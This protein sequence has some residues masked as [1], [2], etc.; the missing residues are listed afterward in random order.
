MDELHLPRIVGLVATLALLV[1]V[2]DN[3]KSRILPA[4]LG[5][6]VLYTA[7]TNIDRATALIGSLQGSL[8]RL[9][10]PRVRTPTRILPGG[11]VER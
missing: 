3:T 7:L 1:W 4:V 11:R 10:Q 5:I 9:Y 2:N 6:L 8:G